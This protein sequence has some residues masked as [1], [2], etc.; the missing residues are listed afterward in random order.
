MNSRVIQISAGILSLFLL[1]YV[2]FQFFSAS[3]HSYTTQTVYAQD[4]VQT[5]PVEGIFF[6][7]ETTIPVEATGVLSSYYSVGTKVPIR[8][9]VACVYQDESAV[10]N[11]YRLEDLQ[12]TLDALKKAQNSASSSDVV[13]PDVLNG[14]ASDYVNKVITGRD[15]GDLS[16]ISQLKA[17]L[18][19]VMARRALVLSDTEGYDESITSLEQEISSLEGQIT[20]NVQEVVSTASGYYVDHVD[21]WE[22][23]LTSEYLEGMTASDVDEFIAGYQGYNASQNAVKI[24]TNHKWQ[25]VVSVSEQELQ[26]L[27]GNR[28]VSLEFP[29]R[30]ES[31]KMTVLSSEMDKDTGKYKVCLQ[32]DT[33]DPFLLGTRVQS[34]EIVVTTYSGLKIPKEALRFPNDE[35]GVYVLIGDKIYF[36]KID[37]IYE[38]TDYVLSR[39][40]YKGDTEGT[41][42]VKLYDTIIVEGKD[43]Y[44]QK[45]LR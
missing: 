41:D 26:S 3:N 34:A 1:I 8:T 29:N 32:G 44:D 6:R 33:I 10:R 27:A 7:E 25:F 36:R 31:V 9:S 15:N 19:E 11:Q 45:L 40:Y 17:S 12:N 35:M 21:G 30:K 37:Q 4:V 22:S 14:Q 2:G 20:G 23:T 38:T 24:V 43:L 13:K 5:I 18:L 16:D 39:T 42:F 28:S